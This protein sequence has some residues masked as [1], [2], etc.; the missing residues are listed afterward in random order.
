MAYLFQPIPV[1]RGPHV[2][3]KFTRDLLP[4]FSHLTDL[5]ANKYRG[6]ALLDFSC[7]LFPRVVGLRGR[8]PLDV[9]DTPSSPSEANQANVGPKSA[10]GSST[11]ML[12]AAK[13]KGKDEGMSSVSSMRR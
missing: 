4:R 2:S 1:P 3:S 11:V 13:K 5:N 6:R 8:W 12:D 10:I 7:L 9:F